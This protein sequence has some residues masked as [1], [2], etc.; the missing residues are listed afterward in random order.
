MVCDRTRSMQI[1]RRLHRYLNR[2]TPHQSLVVLAVPLLIVEPLKLVSLAVLGDGHFIAGLFVMIGAYAG[3]LF[4]TERL[5]PCSNRSFCVSHGL[6]SLGSDLWRFAI[7]SFVGCAEFGP[8][9]AKQPLLYRR[10]NG[11]PM[12]GRDA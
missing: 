1:S 3:S 12:F 8:N 11:C 7:K 4:I 2:L 5:F 6:R 10:A 9:C